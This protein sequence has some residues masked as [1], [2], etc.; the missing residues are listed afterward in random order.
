MQLPDYLEKKFDY[1]DFYKVEMNYPHYG[2][3]NIESELLQT[4]DAVLQNGTIKSG[5]SVA[6]CIG[7]RGINNLP[8]I[9]QIVC[10]RLNKIGAKPFIIPAM[11]SHGGATAKGQTEVLA[12]LGI[13]EEGCKAPIT[14]SMKTMK[15][16]ELL[17]NVPVYFSEDAG[18]MDHSICINRIKPH[19]KFKGPV[20]S[21]LYKMLC[22][23]MGK[24]AGAEAC[25]QAALRYGFSP[26]IKAA[27]DIIISKTNFR[28]GIA[29]VE[30][31]YDDT[32]KIEAI[33]TSELFQRESELLEIAKENFPKLPICKLDALI[34]REI[35]KNISGSGMDPNVTGRAYDLMEDDFS[36]NMQAT[37]LAILDLTKETAGNAIGLGNADIITEK[38]FQKL[39]YQKTITNALTSLSF[40]KAFI[41]LRLQSEELAIKAAF[42]TTG[43]KDISQLKAVIIK[44]T[45]HLSEFWV[46]A[47]LLPELERIPDVK[48]IEKVHLN[49]DQ[50]GDLNF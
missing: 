47:S 27:G 26:V 3:N 23:G 41:P 42:S 38:V 31:K 36:E 8:E 29:V 20:E 4:L 37:R 35:G 40:R 43:I 10:R 21:G 28:F 46:G 34:I 7:S 48:I 5:D 2:L 25:H 45:R 11:G 13:T 30:D 24:H 39:N 12:S 9:V 33:S 1:P 18:Q 15:V 49:F 32:M 17:D 16:G 22:I 6:V 50:N 44:N 14:S 19:T